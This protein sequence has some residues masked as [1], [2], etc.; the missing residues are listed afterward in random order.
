MVE[1]TC[2][3]ILTSIYSHPKDPTDNKSIWSLK[4]RQNGHHFSDNIF[5]AIFFIENC[6]I[7]IEISLRFVL[8][9]PINHIPVLVHIM[10]GHQ[11]GNKTSFEPMMA[12]FN[13]T[14]ASFFLNELTHWHLV[15]PYGLTAPSHYL[16]QCWLIIS[17][18]PWHLSDDV[19]IRRFEDTNH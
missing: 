14:H 4:L 10:V 18:V 8:Q 19:I 7:L 2:H 11:S 16:N 9:G 3:L 1:G 17:K 6:C 13:G 12:R 5:K 15:I